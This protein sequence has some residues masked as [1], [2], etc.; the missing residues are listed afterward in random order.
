MKRKLTYMQYCRKYEATNGGFFSDHYIHQI[1]FLFNQIFIRTNITPNQI[2]FLSLFVG[3]LAAFLV[4][5]GTSW[6]LIAGGILIILSYALDCCDGDI[7]R[8]KK[9]TSKKGSWLD[10]ISDE[11]K[12]S[13][14]IFG[15]TIGLFR[16]TGEL[17][18]FFFGMIALIA[19][20]MT[21]VVVEGA[22]K[23]LEQN[24]LKE[25]HGRIGII[26][27]L[28]RLGLKQKYLALTTDV[29]IT[30]TGIL[31]AINRLPWALA[32]F[33]VVKNLYWLFFS[34]WVWFTAKE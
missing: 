16:Q 30:I 13:S 2:T 12:N 7:A 24:I 27:K 5:Y 22:G 21:F 14:F 26:K 33:I 19:L 8:Y 28:Q 25:S 29:D 34:F 1:S 17:S 10:F 23:R 11:I 31:V 9:M 3:L 6:L 18:V 4:S 15:I 32:Y 20:Y